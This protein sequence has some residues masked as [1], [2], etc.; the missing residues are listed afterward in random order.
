M[1]KF[2][3]SQRGSDR[4]H[5][6]RERKDQDGGDH[7]AEALGQ[8]FRDIP[9]ADSFSDSEIQAGQKIGGQTSQRKGDKRVCIAQRFND[10]PG[11]FGSDPRGLA[12]ESARVQHG[13]GDKEDQQ[14]HGQYEVHDPAPGIDLDI[15]LFLS[16]VFVFHSCLPLGFF[17]FSVVKIHQQQAGDKEQGQQR[18]EIVGDRADEKLY[19]G[20][21]GP[22]IAGHESD[23]CSPGGNRRYHTYGSC[24][25][26][27][28]VGELGPGDLI[29]VCHGT[30]DTSDCQAVKVVVDKDQYAEQKCDQSRASPG[31]DL[32]P[33][34]AAESH[35]AS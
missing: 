21:A 13:K 26:V 28:Q 7:G 35:T 24:R 1:Y 25:R 34:P 22:H 14:Q 30:H 33:C 4:F 18:V 11:I 23:S 17:H 9:Q 20:D 19:S 6:R 31:F 32:F 3:R 27:D 29:L 12:I 8:T 10:I 15:F 5:R 16:A 2:S